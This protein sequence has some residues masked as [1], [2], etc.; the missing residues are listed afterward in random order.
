MRAVL[1]VLAAAAV[2]AGCGGNAPSEPLPSPVPTGRGAQFSLPARP[3]ALRGQP[4]AG[5]R[6]AADPGPR[7]LAHLELFAA[8]RVVPIPPGIGVVPPLRT[9]RAQVLGG[10]CSYPLRTTEPT[11]LI[12]LRRGARATLGDFF[13]LW[14]QPLSRTRMASFRGA[15]VRAY[16]TG[17]RFAGPPADLPLARHAVV[18]LEVGPYLAPHARYRYPPGR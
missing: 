4:V 17:R 10:R 11:G 5:H 7:D 3:A 9:L 8:G 14:G 1:P 2:I 16:L 6:C 18:V 12:E 15:P 13:A